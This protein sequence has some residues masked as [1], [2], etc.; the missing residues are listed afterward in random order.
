MSS[1]PTKLPLA[2]ARP[3][4]RVSAVSRPFRSNWN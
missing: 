4:F 3:L 1:T 2:M